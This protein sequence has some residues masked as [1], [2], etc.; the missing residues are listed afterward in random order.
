MAD[1]P[2]LSV[3]VSVTG[4]LPVVPRRI[5]CACPMKALMTACDLSEVCG[6][7][8][9]LYPGLPLPQPSISASPVRDRDILS[10]ASG[11]N[12]PLLS[13][14]VMSIMTQSC[15]PPMVLRLGRS[16][17][18]DAGLVVSFLEVMRRLPFL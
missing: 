11:T 8:W 5:T 4:C 13:L 12:R 14:R 17:M 1:W 3:A 2:L 16:D 7:S 6:R 9:S 10:Q 18:L 15:V